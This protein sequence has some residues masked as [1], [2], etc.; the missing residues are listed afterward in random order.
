MEF[1]RGGS[2]PKIVRTRLYGDQEFS[3]FELELFHTPLLQ[4][5]YNLKQLGFTDK[6]YPDAV[7]AR[8]NHILGATEVVDRMARRLV[9]WLAANPSVSL[10]FSRSGESTGTIS[11]GD[12]GTL[13]SQRMPT[14]RLMAL[15][16]DVTH[17]AF[18]HTLEDEVNVFDEKHDDPSRQIRFFNALT[19][20]L[21]YFWVTEEGLREFDGNTLQGLANLELS[22][23][24][25]EETRWAQELA[26]ILTAEQRKQLATHLRHL[27]LAQLL[28]LNI[29]FAH[30]KHGPQAPDALLITQV[31]PIISADV[32]AFDLELYRDIFMIDLVGNTICAD[33]LDYARRDADHAGLR[34]QF[35]DR[36]LRYICVVSVEGELA[37]ARQRCIRTA[38]QIFT[39]KMRHDVL[40]EMSGVLKARYLISERVLFHPTKCAAGA[41]LG[42]AVQFLGLRDLPGWIQVLGDDEF[43]HVLNNLASHLAYVATRLEAQPQRKWRDTVRTSW[44][45]DA[46]TANLVERAV[47]WI[48]PNATEAEVKTLSSDDVALLKVRAIAAGNVLSR[49]T[50]RRFAKLVYRLRAAQHSGGETDETLAKKYSDPVKRYA[51]E[52]EVER[53]CHLPAGAVSVHCPNRKTSMKVAE[54]LVVGSNL[55]VVARLAEVTKVSPEGLEPYQREINS[56]QDMYRSIWSFNAFLDPAHWEKWPVV[57]WTFERLLHFPSDKLLSDE[58]AKDAAGPYWLISNELRDEIA[59]VHLGAVVRGVDADSALVRSRFGNTGGDPRERLREIIR[60]AVAAGA[61]EPEQ[62]GLPGVDSR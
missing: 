17:A 15:L 59:P 26:A 4:R 12:L 38:I 16:H 55:D 22:Q 50:A 47:C 40:S 37:P 51:L 58:L 29:E 13:L 8:F 10:A 44:P 31:A 24:S 34:V 36:F 61:G 41:M 21:L 28:L 18:G 39:D 54:V 57:A 9:T 23:N 35:D 56:I 27:E 19:A 5:L 62:L 6:V 3:R 45:A 52:R 48:L 7:H 1:L 2:K 11:A 14:V 20:Q 49:L 25:D 42:T 53:I 46:R 30:G 60:K 33:L 32:L 43:L